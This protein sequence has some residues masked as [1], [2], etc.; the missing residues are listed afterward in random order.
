MKAHVKT[1]Q[2]K[3][4]LLE[5]SEI[6]RIN[7][8][9]MIALNQEFCFGKKRLLDVYAKV[10]SIS[11]ELYEDPEYWLKIDEL[12]LDN[13]GFSDIIERR[14]IFP[15][16][17]KKNEIQNKLSYTEIRLK[18]DVEE[19]KKNQTIGKFCEI[20]SNDYIRIPDTENFF[21]IFEFI[22]H[23]SVKFIFTS[24]FPFE[25]PKINFLAGNQYSY[26]SNEDGSIIMDLINKDKWSPTFWISTLIYYIENKLSSE[27]LKVSLLNNN[28]YSNNNFYGIIKKGNYN[29]RNWNEYLRINHF[30]E[31]NIELLK[32]YELKRNKLTSF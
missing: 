27:T 11:G 31:E 7:K 15:F 8:I 28:N 32:S 29:K 20:I 30:R 17:N 22:N 21:M 6:M 9:W 24:E 23:F 26:L 3:A 19:L 14:R 18:K 5:K 1:A 2:E 13:L 10:C 25:P 4:S 16:P 12:L